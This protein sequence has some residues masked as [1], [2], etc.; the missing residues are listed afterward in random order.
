MVRPLASARPRRL[1]GGEVSA[2]SALSGFDFLLLPPRLRVEKTVS[3]LVPA[4][5]VGQTIGFCRLLQWACGPRNF[6]K[7]V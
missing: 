3:S 6:M 7:K 1:S 4:L 5:P 2:S